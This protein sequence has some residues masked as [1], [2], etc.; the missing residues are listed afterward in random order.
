VLEGNSG[1][2]LM[3]W[4]NSPTPDDLMAEDNSLIG[5]GSHPQILSI[6]NPGGRIVNGVQLKD[7]DCYCAG[8]NA[9]KKL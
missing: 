9:D 8:S 3:Y 4:Q 6:M 5:L 2:L 7:N 1:G